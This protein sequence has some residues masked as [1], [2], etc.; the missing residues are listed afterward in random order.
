MNKSPKISVVIPS[1]NKEKFITK[2][3]DS[4]ISQNYDNFEIIIQDG[5]STDGTTKTI[6]R[7]KHKFSDVIEVVSKKDKGQLDAI[8]KG[9]NKASGNILTFINADDYYLPG[10]FIAISEACRNNPDSLWF[11]GRAFVVD[12]QNKEIAKLVTIYKDILLK[13]NKFNLLLITNYLMQPGVF[14]TREGYDKYGPFTG[15]NNFVTEYELWLRLGKN[16][17]PVVVDNKLCCFRI[18]E[19]TK[20]KNMS[21]E[22]LLED[23]KIVNKF[24]KNPLILFLHRLNNIG[25]LLVEKFI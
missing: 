6:N 23:E 13:A 10:A 17:M 5:G 20:T 22:L 14:I 24:T 9:L 25:R 18:E 4:I 11:A 2:T 3:L 8:L 21:Q 15:T 1:Y 12:G 16:K 7:Y 19:T